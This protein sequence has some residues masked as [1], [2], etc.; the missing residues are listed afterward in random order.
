MKRIFLL[1][2]FFIG[3]LPIATTTLKAQ[4]IHLVV[5]QVPAKVKI[6]FEKKYPQGNDVIWQREE[7]GLYSAQ[8]WDADNDLYVNAYL[9]EDGT[10]AKSSMEVTPESFTEAVRQYMK[11]NYRDQPIANVIA[12]QE[13]AGKVTFKVELE[14]DNKLITLVFDKSAN[15]LSKTEEIINFEISED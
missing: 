12:T 11:V 14:K 15:V 5:E 4:P 6:G 10:W 7:N 13:P 1:G 3:L 2:I 9:E 8:F